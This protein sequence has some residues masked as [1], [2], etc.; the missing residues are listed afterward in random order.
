MASM[1]RDSSPPEAGLAQRARRHP[2]VGREDELGLVLGAARTERLESSSAGL[3]D[4]IEA[5]V[6]HGQVAQ[7]AGHAGGEGCSGGG[8]CRR[9][10]RGQ[11]DG[12]GLGAVEPRQRGRIVG[13]EPFEIGEPLAGGRRV[14][15]DRIGRTAV[16]AGQQGEP[17]VAQLDGVAVCR[18]DVRSSG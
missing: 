3:Q 5:H 10:A 16:L 11:R 7:L 12:L 13:G 2:G 6:R 17:V 4:D 9:E 8:A 18:V 1:A 14:G 15:D